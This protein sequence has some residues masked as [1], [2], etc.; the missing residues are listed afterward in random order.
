MRKWKSAL[1]VVLLL[2]VM[3]GCTERVPVGF[4]GMNQTPDGLT[5]ITLAPGNHSSWGRDTMILVENREDTVTEKLSVLMKDE[6]N[7]KFDVKIRTRLRVSDGKGIKALL[8]RKG[9]QIVNATVGRVLPFSVLYGTYV[10]PLARAKSRAVVS[11]YET[12]QMR[13]AR[14][15]IEAKIFKILV[16]SVA[17]TP[18]EIVSVVSSNFDYPEIITK[19]VEKKRKREIEIGEEKAKQAVALLR[20]DNRMKIAQKMKQVRAAEAQAESV[21]FK[22]LGDSM[23]PKYLAFR[24][25][26]N[27]KILYSKA[28]TQLVV[29][30]GNGVR[31]LINLK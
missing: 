1:W 20:I 13:A 8:N 24:Q 31:P 6:L 19:A 15:E 25:K 3:V 22:I 16:A 23:T 28:G 12:T 30:G 4:V 5:G 9:S 17:D 18:M 7:F 29:L 2:F 27:E 11:T 10:Q 26:E 14:A 21:A